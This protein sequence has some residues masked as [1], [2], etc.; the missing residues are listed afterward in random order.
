MVAK[1]AVL[2]RW[3]GS[4]AAIAIMRAILRRGPT[5]CRRSHRGRRRARYRARG[6]TIPIPVPSSRS[7]RRRRTSRRRRRRRRC[8]GRS[9]TETDSRIRLSFMAASA[10]FCFINTITTLVLL[11]RLLRLLA[12]D[13]LVELL[14]KV[15]D[16]HGHAALHDGA[17]DRQ[18]ALDVPADNG[19]ARRL[20]LGRVVAP[21]LRKHPRARRLHLADVTE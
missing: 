7:R 19:P 13:A 5:V 6:P 10:G 2:R 21:E 1:T 8:S 4:V 15:H 18:I 14:A 11:L 3:R 9:R 20:A 12:L 16:A 17:G